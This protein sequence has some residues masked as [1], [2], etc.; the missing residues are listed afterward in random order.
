MEPTLRD[1]D[2]LLV[3]RQAYKDQQPRP[4]DLV[5]AEGDPWLIKR[6]VQVEAATLALAGDHPAHASD[7]LEVAAGALRGRPWFRYWPLRR[8]GRIR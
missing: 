4:D 1:G 7:H 8:I 5:V 6:V 3:D 2:W